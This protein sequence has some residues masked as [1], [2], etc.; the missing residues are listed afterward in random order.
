MS[1]AT[2][3]TEMDTRII[4]FM[5]RRS[6]DNMSRTSKYYRQ[7][8]EP[9]LYR[10]LKFKGRDH[11]AIMHLS[12][13]LTNRQDLANYIK[14]FKLDGIA[15]QN[16]RKTSESLSY[17]LLKSITNI[18]NIIVEVLGS[19]APAADKLHWLSALVAEEP[20]VD[21]Y[22]ATNLD[23]FSL[24]L[25][26]YKKPLLILLKVMASA[27]MPTTQVVGPADS[28]NTLETLQIISEPGQML[29]PFAKLQHLCIENEFGV[30]IPV[31]PSLLTFNLQWSSSPK[32]TMAHFKYIR[33]T[34]YKSTL[35][36]KHFSQGFLP[37]A[38]PTS[39]RLNSVA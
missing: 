12:V 36:E 25:G 14:S 20:H 27:R 21:G 32:P 7:I 26:H 5:D 13:V 17:Q 37:D 31:M 9:L 18:N 6:L 15:N 10:H 30:T 2:L 28:N 3:S 29:E 8:T 4:S 38:S 23:S 1:F 33:W 11:A 22:L 34:S 19:D 24:W 39:I 35:N 16:G